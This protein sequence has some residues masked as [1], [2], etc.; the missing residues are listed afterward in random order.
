MRVFNF[1]SKFTFICNIAFLLFVFFRWLELKKP[2]ATSADKVVDVPFFKDL[3]ITL[4]VSA[5]IINLLMNIFYVLFLARGKMK[6]IPL[7]LPVVNF[8]FLILQIIYFF[9]Y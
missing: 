5:I 9:F 6:S 2:A 1:L 8:M 3:I 4:G 7:W